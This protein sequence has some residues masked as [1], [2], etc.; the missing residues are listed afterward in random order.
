LKAQQTLVLTR[1]FTVPIQQVFEAWTQADVLAKW[2]GPEGFTVVDA[3]TDLSV[4]GQYEITIKSPDNNLIKHFGKYVEIKAPN[5]LIFTWELKDQTCAGS[6]GQHVT[7]LVTLLFEETATK[8]T[9]LTLTHEKLPDQ[10]AFAG[11][12]FGWQSSL[13]V[14]NQYLISI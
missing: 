5:S 9:L 3:Q 14:L 10:A 2:F 7:T 1:E 4:G 8:S 13:E 12:Q 6:E 11:H